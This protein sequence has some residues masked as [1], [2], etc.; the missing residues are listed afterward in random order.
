[1]ASKPFTFYVILFLTP[2]ITLNIQYLRHL[3]ANVP[4]APIYPKPAMNPSWF[5]FVARELGDDNINIALVNMDETTMTD[6]DV[7]TKGKIV[8]V[9]FRPVDK[10]TQWSNLYPVWIVENSAKCPKI[11]MPMFENYE[12]LD[13]VVARVPS[14]ECVEVAVRDV[15]RL[16][17]NLVVANLLVRCGRLESGVKKRPIFAVFIGS[18]GPMWE[19]FRCDDLVLHD[20]DSWIYKPQLTRMKQIVLMPVG[21][22]QLNPPSAHFG[23]ELWMQTEDER[24]MKQPREAYSSILHSSERYVCGAIALAQSI[25]Q[26]NTTKDLVL[27]VD[28]HH[29]S[30]KSIDDLRSAGWKIRRI[31]R[32]RNPHSIKNSYNEWNYSKLRL[33][34]LVEYD[35]VMFIDSDFIVT[36]SLDEFFIYPGISA[37]G[38]NEYRFNSGLM[39]LEPSLCTFKTLMERRWLVR[40]YNGGDQGFLNEMFPWWHRLP[41]KINHLTYFESNIGDNKDHTVPNDAYAIHYLGLKPWWCYRDYDCN[42]DI[43][44][45]QK[46]ASDSA[47][48]I[49]WDAYDK[50]PQN[51]RRHCFLTPTMH[52]S[53]REN[54]N[55]AEEANLPDGH[56]RIKIKD[57]RLKNVL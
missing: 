12:D 47:N 51:L 2:L 8:T 24:I 33:W 31:Q 46:F 7:P 55:K 37:K 41:N 13:V 15:F 44:E 5:E 14:N 53:N 48:T 42:W 25:I 57:P 18:S 22:C 38:N 43:P 30:P 27:L 49:W 39:L 3:H 36:R 26:S 52:T 34:Q 45:R 28:D 19:I 56:W 21:T 29:V 17:V 32:I 23:E 10:A 20:A 40:S 50:M 16:Q 11:P 1:M 6:K 54:R 9:D 35:K 4:N